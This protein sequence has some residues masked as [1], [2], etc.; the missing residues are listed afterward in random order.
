M[1]LHLS[2]LLGPGPN[3][4]FGVNAGIIIIVFCDL[5]YRTTWA[6]GMGRSPIFQ[7]FSKEPCPARKE[8]TEEVATKAT[9][10]CLRSVKLQT[11]TGSPGRFK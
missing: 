5:K 1:I 7:A 8:A 10:L 2:G 11:K 6:G 4:L 3:Q 9:E